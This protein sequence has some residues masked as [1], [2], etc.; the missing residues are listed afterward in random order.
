M[1]LQTLA[2][3]AATAL[4]NTPKPLDAAANG[5]AGGNGLRGLGYQ[6]A[7]SS[8]KPKADASASGDAQRAAPEKPAADLGKGD[9]RGLL[10]GLHPGM[11]SRAQTMLALAQARGLNVWVVEGMRSFERQ[12]Q[13]YAQGRTKPGNKVTWVRGGGSY[14]NY[15]LAIDVVFHGKEPWGNQHDWNALGQ[16]GRDA[17]LE[18]GGSFGDRPHFQWSV[19]PTKTLLQ[20]YGAGGLD[21]VW[22]RIDGQT[23]GEA[24]DQARKTETPAAVARPTGATHTVKSGDTLEAIARTALGDA[25][26]WQEIATLNSIS[27]PRRLRIGQ[28]LRLPGPANENKVAPPVAAVEAAAADATAGAGANQNAP[29]NAGA[30]PNRTF[31]IANQITSIMEGGTSSAKGYATVSVVADGG[32]V[33]Y[34][35][36]QSTLASGSLQAILDLYL[37]SATSQTAETLRGYMPRVRQKDASLARDNGFVA[38]LKA[39]ASEKSMQ[40]AQDQV[41]GSR[42]WDPAVTRAKGANIQ[43]P[44]GYAM[45][46]DTQIQGGL[47]ECMTTAT[48][49]VGG[50]P[51][52]K[53]GDREITELSF[54]QA[55]NDAREARLIRLADRA[56]NEGKTQRANALRNSTYRTRAFRSLLNAGNLQV[57]GPGGR[58]E[59]LG[60]G[61]GTY[62]I[63]GNDSNAAPAA[64]PTG[65]QNGTTGA[66]ATPATPATKPVEAAPRPTPRP[67]ARGQWAVVVAAGGLNVRSGPSAQAAKLATMS[68]GQR[69]E[70]I[71]AQGNWSAIKFGGRTAWAYTS[72]LDMVDEVAQEMGV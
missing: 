51:G 54:L 71:G 58:V 48:T 60:P 70:V 30:N 21:N 66:N 67:A 13:L 14:H 56:A 6:D 26:R 62:T 17:G 59:I 39:A 16:A 4:E 25:E 69:V 15:G 35:K 3:S 72:Y 27:D 1:S 43:S 7:A 64:I 47:A 5:A 55:F 19:A 18:W 53:V 52:Q 46:Y 34:G 22:R 8:L 33:S 9:P 20:W 10:A 57:A 49:Q 61:N 24:E 63:E 29:G 36:H 45:L 42:Y 50:T 23:G 28:V 44:L 38:A 2:P 41:F 11:Q 37:A 68:R 65:P 32:I 12:N 40:L 31:D